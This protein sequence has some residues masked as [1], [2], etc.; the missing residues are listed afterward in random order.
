M[1]KFDIKR[2]DALFA[3]LEI[4]CH[5]MARQDAILHLLLKKLSI[6]DEDFKQLTG[7]VY[8]QYQSGMATSVERIFEN[9]GSLDLTKI[10]N[11]EW[12]TDEHE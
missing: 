6:N 11:G 7:E 4:A 2:E 5:I 1:D 9:Y 3:T 10:L 12:K 8:E